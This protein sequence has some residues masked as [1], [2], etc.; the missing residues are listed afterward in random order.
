MRYNQ[1]RIELGAMATGMFY[2]AQKDRINC[3]NRIRQII[4]RQIEGKDLSEKC[5]KKAR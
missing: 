2:A 3:F 4:Y 5:K 1:I